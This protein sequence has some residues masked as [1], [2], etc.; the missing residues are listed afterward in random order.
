MYNIRVAHVIIVI[1]E[2]CQLM[3]FKI[4]T[5]VEFLFYIGYK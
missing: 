1:Y 3:K 4:I 2:P 5:G